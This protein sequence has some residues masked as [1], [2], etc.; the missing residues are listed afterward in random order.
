MKYAFVESGV[1]VEVVRVDPFGIFNTGYASKFV[2]VPDEV[3]PG[4][5]FDGE[6][7]APPVPAP[8]PIPD[9]RITKLAFRNRFAQAEK[10][11]IE[12]AALDDPSASMQARMQ[13]AA[14]RAY[15]KDAEA[16]T[17]IDLSRQDLADGVNSLEAAGVIAAGRAQE[18]LSHDIADVERYKG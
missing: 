4:W 6:S 8:D 11:A 12:F 18:I 10:A 13:S 7:F 5:V 2:E 15:L 17:F 14:L 3:E 16:A 9:L 1:V